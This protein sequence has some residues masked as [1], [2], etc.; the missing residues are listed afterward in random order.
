MWRGMLRTNPVK[1]QRR[2]CAAAEVATHGVRELFPKADRAGRQRTLHSHYSCEESWTEASLKRSIEN[3]IADDPAASG[4]ESLFLSS[5]TKARNRSAKTAPLKTQNQS[6]IPTTVRAQEYRVAD[7][8]TYDAK[9]SCISPPQ[10]PSAPDAVLRTGPRETS[11][12]FTNRP[13]A[14]ASRPGACCP[15]CA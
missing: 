14:E 12:S 2:P 6:T 15:R 11:G 5:N 3:G 7:Q 13:L 8:L 9:T 1:P 10:M 4:E